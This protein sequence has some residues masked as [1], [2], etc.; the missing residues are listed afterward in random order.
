MKIHGTAEEQPKQ[1]AS[2]TDRALQAVEE[3]LAERWSSI[4]A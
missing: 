2:L 1:M 3:T 4:L